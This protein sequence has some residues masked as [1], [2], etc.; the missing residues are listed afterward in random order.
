MAEISH[1]Y[2]LKRLK[3]TLAIDKIEDAIPI[4][5]S[6]DPDKYVPSGSPGI[7][8]KNNLLD[9]RKHELL[10]IVF[11]FPTR[12]GARPETYIEI[13]HRNLHQ[14]PQKNLITNHKVKVIDTFER[15]KLSNIATYVSTNAAI[16]F[17]IYNL[18][19]AYNFW[20]NISS[21]CS[22]YNH[23]VAF[24]HARKIKNSR[25]SIIDEFI[26]FISFIDLPYCIPVFDYRKVD[27]MGIYCGFMYRN[28]NEKDG[29]IETSIINTLSF[30]LSNYQEN[31]LYLDGIKVNKP[32]KVHPDT[33]KY[34]L[35]IIDYEIKYSK[36]NFDKLD[37]EKFETPDIHKAKTKDQESISKLPEF[38][39]NDKGHMWT[40]LFDKEQPEIKIE[41]PIITPS[42][43]ENNEKP[44]WRPS[45]EELPKS[46]YTNISTGT[47]YND[48]TTEFAA[49]WV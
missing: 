29:K 43:I 46:R 19:N 36:S 14:L 1:L 37:I 22:K 40:K 8:S 41:D 42:R 49:K 6:F 44:I 35:Q 34:M 17:I 18:V 11:P 4:T 20:E 45:V 16:T 9:D 3:R 48:T 33:I 24:Y 47:I 23:T 32:T 13:G 26:P 15:S 2:S 28:T 7:I 31:L 30:V 5:I 12:I 27:G 25:K 38:K 21:L 10:R 39:L